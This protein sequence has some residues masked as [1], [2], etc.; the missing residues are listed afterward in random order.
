MSLAHFARLPT[1]ET[2]PF[3]LIESM[4]IKP[5]LASESPSIVLNNIM[6]QNKISYPTDNKHLLALKF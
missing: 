1:L 5:L 2:N 3:R 4:L 6:N